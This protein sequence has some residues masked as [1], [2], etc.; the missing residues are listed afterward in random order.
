MPPLGGLV[1]TEEAAVGVKDFSWAVA[2]VATVKVFVKTTLPPSLLLHGAFEGEE[3]EVFLKGDVAPMG[4]LARP[5]SASTSAM[6]SPPA[7]ESKVS[8][9][10]M[11]ASRQLRLL[12]PGVSG[13]GADV[14]SGG[15]ACSLDLL[16]SS[17]VGDLEGVVA[18]LSR[19]GELLRVSLLS[20]VGL[21]SR[22]RGWHLGVSV[23]SSLMISTLLARD[24]MRSG[25]GGDSSLSSLSLD[26]NFTLLKRPLRP[27]RCRGTGWDTVL[28]RRL[29]VPLRPP[30]SSDRKLRD[31]AELAE[32]M[33]GRPSARARTDSSPSVSSSACSISLSASCS[34][35]GAS[36]SADTSGALPR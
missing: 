1:I 36:V 10:E 13:G 35:S 20:A 25:L 3:D 32:E 5:H 8:R 14:G 31:L 11:S 21:W 23:R 19:T 2:V 34:P 30:L 7:I 26:F 12:S 16:T 24:D 6:M 22:E 28:T 4:L 33:E 27:R 17:A 9:E 15:G 18:A 29:P